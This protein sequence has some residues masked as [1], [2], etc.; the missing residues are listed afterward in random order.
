VLIHDNLKYAE[1]SLRHFQKLGNVTNH[2][3]VFENL[4]HLSDKD[5]VN[6][7]MDIL[8]AGADTTASTLTTAILHILQNPEIE[9]KLV[10]AIHRAFPNKQDITLMGLEKVEYLVSDSLLQSHIRHSTNE[11]WPRRMRA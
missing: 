3:V 4:E 7:S 6:E 9:Y 8:I 2:P 5:Q 10:D 1:S 11:L